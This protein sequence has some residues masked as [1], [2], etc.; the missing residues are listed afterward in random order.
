MT[1]LIKL[2]NQE[3]RT[4]GEAFA[5]EFRQ[6]PKGLKRTLTYDQSREIAQHKLFSKETAITVYFAHPSSPW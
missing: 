1:F 4:I 3:A 5:E 2:K 6:L